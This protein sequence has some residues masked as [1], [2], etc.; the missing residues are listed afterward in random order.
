M[1]SIDLAQ[2]FLTLLESIENGIETGFFMNDLVF[3]LQMYY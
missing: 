2:E 3:Q 1:F